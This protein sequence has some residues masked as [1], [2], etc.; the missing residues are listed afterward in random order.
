MQVLRGGRDWRWTD[1]E[2]NQAVLDEERDLYR[3]GKNIWG[4][5]GCARCGV[6]CYVLEVPE[7]NKPAYTRCPH[8]K[9]SRRGTSCELQGRDKPEAC[10]AWSCYNR[11]GLEMPAQRYLFAQIAVDVLGTKSQRDVRKIP[12]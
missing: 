3:S 4:T 6:C 1:T 12:K 7:I 9:T 2:F 5:G 10:K 11:L 8:L